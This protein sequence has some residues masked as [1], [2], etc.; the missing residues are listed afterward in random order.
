MFADIYRNKKVLVTGHTG[1]KGSWLTYWLSQLGA[2]VY[3]IAL[4]PDTDPNHWSLLNLAN[5]Q[6][7]TD[8][9]DYSTLSAIVAE[10]QPDI[11]FHLAAQPIVRLSYSEPLQTWSTNVMGTVNVLEA[12]RHVASVKTIVVVTSDKC[13]ENHEKRGL[14]RIGSTGWA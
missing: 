2:R 5:P 10:F 12:C 14:Y 11:V 1:F 6:T 13:Y 7:L 3:G 8:I 9:R 4:E